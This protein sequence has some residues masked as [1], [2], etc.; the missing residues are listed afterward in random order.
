MVLQILTWWLVS[1][2]LGLAAL[3]L[4][5]YLFRSLPDRGYPFARAL[6]LLLAG[7]LAWLLAILGLAPFGRGLLVM[8]AVV[9]LAV[10]AF[11]SRAKNHEL[12]TAEGRAIR[13][14]VL[15]SRLSALGS[16]FFPGWRLT[17]SYE[18]IFLAA[19]VFMA[20]LRARNPD[21]WGT[22]RP[23]DF[24]LFNA[25]QHSS[26]FPPHDPWLSGF[27]INYYYLGYLL[28][29]VMA[30]LSGLEASVAFNLSLA[31]IYALTALGIAGVVM[32]LIGLSLPRRREN[33]KNAEE[34]VSGSS[35]ATARTLR[36]RAFAVKSAVA[37]FA[38]V[39]VL[40]AGNQ[41]GT[42][43]LITGTPRVLFLSGGDM[44]RA[45]QNGFGP[46]QPLTLNTPVQAWG[47]NPV[48]VITPTNT[49]ENFDMWWPSRAVW[50]RAPNPTDKTSY[51]AITEFP[52]FSFFLGDMHP[53]VIAL[54]FGLL[55]FALALATLARPVAPVFT[56]TW[57][58]W[59]E[60]MLTGIVLGS[61]YMINSWDF[62]TYVL[63]Y[64]GALVL[65]YV[66]LGQAETAT[67]RDG[68]TATQR[69]GNAGEA[70]VTSLQPLAPDAHPGT[71]LLEQTQNAQ[72]TTHNAHILWP[73]LAQ[74]AM[75]ATF[76][77][78]VLF[79]PFFLTFK[80]LVGSKE[81]LIALPLLGS[82][83][84]IIGFVHWVK[85]PLYSFV[86]IFGL[87]LL[88]LL[89]FI[90]GVGQR[91]RV[92]AASERLMGMR[93][94]VPP[95]GALGIVARP[96]PPPAL[97]LVLPWTVLAALVLGLF[98]GFPLLF[99]LPLGLYAV[100]LAVNTVENPGVSFALLAAA[101]GAFICFGTE[102]IYIRD[103][104]E[105]GAS[106][107]NTIFKFYYQV[108][109]IWGMLAAYA[110][111]WIVQGSGFRVQESGAGGAEPGS[112][113]Q[114]ADTSP[115]IQRRERGTSAV[116]LP[117]FVFRLSSFV[118]LLVTALCFASALTY[119][120]F[121]AFKKL[122]EQPAISLQGKTPR[123]Q[124]A[125]GVA[126]IEWLRQNGA[127]NAVIL[128]ANGGENESYDPSG[129]GI[130]GVSASSGLATVIGWPGHEG[131]W[132][133]GDPAARAQI[134]PRRADVETLYST[135]DL[136]QARALLVQYNVSFVYVGEAE[137]QRFAVESLAKFAQ[138]GK[139]V[140]QQDEVVIYRI[141][142]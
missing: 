91:L 28:M 52:M 24:A 142:N 70:P 82:L 23:M 35:F 66:R 109:L 122:R 57:R 8:C 67:R 80:S 9:V 69:V 71:W 61:L 85:T 62:P 30:L 76:A 118:C 136:G 17:A 137:R 110:V 48:S 78:F 38:V 131:Q 59:L 64:L 105:G 55:A 89:G 39:L 20:L 19:L 13:T 49:I 126:S 88:P 7:Y 103:V 134:E 138:L 33:T 87:F 92:A 74:H 60:L 10:G 29:A 104:F 140:F 123:Q 26:S 133:G 141:A 101:L 96:A 127:S 5:T 113:G 36:L 75:L 90:F 45:I 79:A 72:R 139:P 14:S 112:S 77:S 115:A 43:A 135:T 73:Q 15:G 93:V 117:S 32:N 107:M 97:L 2:L 18:L 120:Y 130:G 25:I 50:D 12:R 27:S 44:L 81:P 95:V 16:R 106:R 65:L 34:T 53:H 124:T 46:R 84:S 111:W 100:L 86:I 132:R 63:L 40:V 51:Y 11:A 54:P 114:G 99:L 47:E 21:P 116:G 108:W 129:L 83:T 4:T 121:T 42:L 119:P 6:G 3:P 56:L 125:A 22:E 102:L 41:G 31:L 94:S 37:V 1:T 58:G 128:E 98:F 68:E